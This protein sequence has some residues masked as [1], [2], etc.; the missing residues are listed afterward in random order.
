MKPSYALKL[1]LVFLVSSGVVSPL[2][3]LSQ[4]DPFAQRD[5]SISTK[6]DLHD[7][8]ASLKIQH[9]VS[10]KHLGTGHPNVARLETEISVIERLLGIPSGG[11]STFD[12]KQA[13][14]K[15]EEEWKGL[16]AEVTFPSEGQCKIELKPSKGKD[17]S[18]EFY[19]TMAQRLRELAPETAWQILFHDATSKTF[20]ASPYEGTLV[21]KEDDP[22]AFEFAAKLW[23]KR[24]STGEIRNQFGDTV[25]KLRSTSDSKKRSQLSS[26]LRILIRYHL[27]L[28]TTK[29]KEQIAAA[30]AK[31]KE[32]KQQ[33][34][35]RQMNQQKVAEALALLIENPTAGGGLPAEWLRG[36]FSQN[37][38]RNSDP[39]AASNDDPF[40]S[41]GDNPFGQ[42]PVSVADPF[43][44]GGDDPFGGPTAPSDDPFARP[45][46]SDPFGGP[47]SSSN[48][49]FGGPGDSDPFGSSSP[50][51]TKKSATGQPSAPTKTPD[52]PFGDPRPAFEIALGGKSIA[53]YETYDKGVP[54]LTRET[55]KLEQG[56]TQT[57]QAAV[58]NSVSV[59][60]IWMTRKGIVEIRPSKE[61][62][63]SIEFLAKE[64]G[65]TQIAIR[66]YDDTIHRFNITVIPAPDPADLKPA[67]QSSGD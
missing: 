34:S 65:K 67:L 52:N 64:P 12:E 19:M 23:T 55:W 45:G 2:A 3:V 59:M 9:A 27:E 18:R 57:V 21:S 54:V 6:S 13:V 25:R 37:F 7:K 63:D 17:L 40:A 60:S 30:E 33:V 1:S 46:G 26:L 49:P 32:L 47:S 50:K 24:L 41:A 44:A 28:E 56:K 38:N 62:P 36:A 20:V 22:K 31:L 48:D 61:D 29:A 4:D 35:Q 5:S 53:V 14:R 8:L 11:A 42:T 43:A 58:A 10:S 66:N 51:P 15:I 39:F 16:K